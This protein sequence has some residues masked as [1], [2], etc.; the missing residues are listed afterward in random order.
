MASIEPIAGK[1][2]S[3]RD[4]AYNQYKLTA[5]NLTISVHS[6]NGQELLSQPWRYKIHFTCANKEINIS[7]ILSQSASLTFQ[8]LHLAKQLTK[9]S[10][11]EKP[12]QPRPLYGVITEFSLLSVS[13]DEAR[14]CVVLQPR[15]YLFANQ[16]F[17]VIY[18]NQSVVS[19]VEV[20]RMQHGF[21][22]VD[23][24]LVPKVNYP[25]RQFITQWQSDLEFIQRL[26]IDIGIWFRF[27]S[28]TEHY[29]DVL[30]LSDYQQGLEHTGTITFKAPSN[31]VDGLISSVCDLQLQNKMV[32]HKIV[33][34]DYNYR[35]V[36]ANQYSRV[37]SLPQD[38][39]TIGT[40]Y[41]YGE[42][43][44]TQG[45][46]KQIESGLWYAEIRHEHYI[47]AK[48]IL[49][50]VYN[51]YHPSSDQCI[52]I[53]GSPISGIGED[54]IILSTLSHGDRRVSYQTHFTAIP[55][56]VLRPYLSKSLAWPQV[57]GTLLIKVNC[58][59]NDIYS[60]ID[61]QER[62]QVKFDF[63]LETWKHGEGSLWVR[64]AKPY[65]GDTYGFH[66]PLIDDAD[67]AIAF[68][69]DNPDRPNIAHALHDST[70]PD[71]V[72]TAQKHRNV[73]RTPTNNKLRMD[74]KRSQEHIKLATEYGK[75]QLNIAHLVN[76]NKEQRGERTELGTS[77]NV[78]IKSNAMLK[79]RPANLDSSTNIPRE[80]NFK[81]TM[82]EQIQNQPAYWLWTNR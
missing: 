71:H 4:T 10:S 26:L 20:I 38:N 23:H 19:V 54:V 1:L 59:N 25:A 53:D 60:Y 80:I 43:D 41:R 31:T 14:Y 78:L 49:H 62:Y 72:T 34:Q 36:E 82:N 2:A 9:I 6:I 24:Q 67:V 22:G 37:N 69:E 8:S 15:L 29:C 42:H 56:D 76:E 74:D 73:M 18:Q 32:K 33:T 79:M 81:R 50:G 66:F 46:N 64:L 77:G 30:V 61:S 63:N 47:N 70:H 7:S 11:L 55:Y 16:R 51:D 5:D 52:I 44:K 68:I 65:S 28:H 39:T 48:S 27:E 35:T 13:K 57:S 58:P 17:R 45:D 21:T 12:T 40:N 75:T 3:V